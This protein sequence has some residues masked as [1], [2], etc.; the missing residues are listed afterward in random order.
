MK[1]KTKAE[2]ASIVFR[3]CGGLAALFLILSGRLEAQ[4][5]KQ[6]EKPA[7]QISYLQNEAEFLVFKI[8][9]NNT[10]NKKTTLRISDSNYDV[11]FSD[12]VSESY[13]RVVKIPRHEL[14]TIE[15]RVS[16]GKDVV[17]KMFDVKLTTKEVLEVTES[18]TN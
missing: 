17:R 13:S 12:A 8:N 10:S 18:A 16:N 9:I 14:E 5:A 2:T 7:M 6:D 3:Y 4:Q 1:T 15:F 11:L